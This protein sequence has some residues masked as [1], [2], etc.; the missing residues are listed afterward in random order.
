M[1]E[2]FTIPIKEANSC[3]D[4]ARLFIQSLGSDRQDPQELH[5]VFTDWQVKLLSKF[6]DDS[7]SG[8]TNDREK[9]WRKFHCSQHMQ[10]GFHFLIKTYKFCAI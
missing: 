9:L 4:Q 5:T 7:M 3:L 2:G 1:D 10:H 6:I 8:G